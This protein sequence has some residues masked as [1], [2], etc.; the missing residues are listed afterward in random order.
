MPPPERDFTDAAEH[1]SEWDD[2]FVHNPASR[3]RRRI[4]HGL[5]ARN[6]L[7][8]KNVVDI[9]CGDGRMLEEMQRRY[10]CG[11]CGIEP[12]ESSCRRRMGNRL[13]GFH[14]I[15]IQKE[16]V[17]ERFDLLLCTEL[18][19]HVSD[20][21]A[22]IG[23]IARMCAAGAHLLVTVP[24]GPMRKTDFHMGHVRHYSRGELVN[25]LSEGG[26]TELECF[27][28]GYPFHTLYRKML[29]IFP[30][31]IMN[32]FARTRYSWKD[33]LICRILYCMFFLNSGSRG[34][35][36]FYLGKKTA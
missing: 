22:V 6:R 9:G 16:H 27:A 10:N 13:D 30:G 31:R 17:P 20:I 1:E 21:R 14:K 36:M 15:D 4:L 12:G 23:N 33:R 26:F 28:W 11:I 32:S 18:F 25:L 8:F 7:A 19:E 35:Q 29:D 3:H 5:I 34:N 24:T 2:F